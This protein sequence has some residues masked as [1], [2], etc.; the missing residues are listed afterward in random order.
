MHS[1][2]IVNRKT[3]AQLW[4]QIM[5]TAKPNRK[6]NCTFKCKALSFPMRNT[7]PLTA[8]LFVKGNSVKNDG[9]RL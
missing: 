2:A 8:L 1:I 7:K 3:L 5:S 9:N 4:H 6:S